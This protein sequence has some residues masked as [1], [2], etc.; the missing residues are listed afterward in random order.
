[1]DELILRDYQEELSTKAAEIV[2]EHNIV[3][4]SAEV[5]TGKTIMALET[6]KKI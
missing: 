3:L 4:L 6:I 2:M 5:R 1:M